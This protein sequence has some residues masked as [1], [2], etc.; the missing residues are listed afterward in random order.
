MRD[1]NVV[2]TAAEGKFKQAIRFLLMFGPT[3]KTAFYNV[4]MMRADNVA[5]LLNTLVAE[6][7]A[8]GGRLLYLHR[9]IP[10]TATFTFNDRPTF[11]QK[12]AEIARTWAPQLTGKSFHVRMHRRGFKDRLHSVEE[13]HFLN[14]TLIEAAAGRGE[15]GRITFEDPDAVIALETIGTDAGLS[16]WFR[17]DL[18][19]YPF[20]HID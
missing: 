11:Q 10:V 8:E 19:R 6:S 7:E 18:K 3:E 5:D 2:A 16:L 1:W 4:F 20:L 12:A 17:D 9:V 15:T 13:E 14:H